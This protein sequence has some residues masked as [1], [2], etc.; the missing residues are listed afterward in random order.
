MRLCNEFPPQLR[1]SQHIGCRAAVQDIIGA[2]AA[3]QGSTS[4]GESAKSRGAPAVYKHAEDTD[5]RLLKSSG[6]DLMM[7]HAASSNLT[8][9]SAFDTRMTCTLTL[10]SILVVGLFQGFCGCCGVPG[11]AWTQL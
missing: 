7:L 8:G 10:T 1:K 2:C 5:A 6:E 3:V 11:R 4:T 9:S